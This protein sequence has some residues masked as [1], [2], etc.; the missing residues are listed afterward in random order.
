MKILDKAADTGK[1]VDIEERFGSLA[2][3]IIGR[4]VF[5][6]DFNSTCD[7]SPVVKAAISTLK[8][9]EHRAMTPFPYWNI[10]FATDIVPR[11]VKFKKDM[12]LLN[13]RLNACIKG[14]L[15][16]A[17]KEDTEALQNRDYT[18][19]E[20]PS[21]IRFMV[22]MRDEDVTSTQLRDDL[23]TMLIA[24][25]ETT[26]SALTWAIFE[27]AQNPELLARVQAEVDEWLPDPDKLPT[28]DTVRNLELT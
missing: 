11:Q 5:D 1:I 20:D 25:H 9:T 13:D 23:M 24:G 8:E 22:D 3:D 19:I 16:T 26:A 4:A 10:P 15:Q 17:K 21:M 27:L 28:L 7:E 2:L 18:S 12:A 14:A 6:Y